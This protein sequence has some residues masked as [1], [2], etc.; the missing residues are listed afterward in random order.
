[1]GKRKI[2][3]LYFIRDARAT[4]EEQAEIDEFGGKFLVGVRNAAF[5]HDDDNIEDFDI[6][7]GA[8]PAIYAKAAKTKPPIEE[9]K[10]PRSSKKDVAP[11]S[12]IEPPA[13]PADAD[14]GSGEAAPPADAA[15]PASEPEKAPGEPAADTAKPK[16]P[17]AKPEAAKGWRGNS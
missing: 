7:A 12:P 8:V 17:E 14:Q 3:V 1:M 11:G 9:L 4:E 2:K 10:K 13:P 6:V 15:P 16:A 5:V